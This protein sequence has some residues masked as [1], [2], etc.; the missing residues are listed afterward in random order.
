MSPYR[1]AEML[2][3]GSVIS[4]GLAVSA[5]AVALTAV[6][7]PTPRLA[8]R[9]MA[10]AVLVISPA[11]AAQLWSA[12]APQAADQQPLVTLLPWASAPILL[13]TCLLLV[14][15]R[16]QGSRWLGFSALALGVTVAS[17]VLLYLGIGVS[18]YL[19]YQILPLTGDKA[20]F[21]G[22]QFSVA[23]FGAGLLLGC[24]A[25]IARVGALQ[26]TKTREA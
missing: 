9:A 15:G 5:M 23:A 18:Y 12:T 16:P 19:Q 25:L 21:D 11:I 7:E 1:P 22:Y 14:K 17:Y 6:R 24:I 13:L 10:I 2:F 26:K 3:A 4:V 8:L 20:F